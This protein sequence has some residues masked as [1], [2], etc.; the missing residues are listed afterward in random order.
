[1]QKVV[2]DTN[3]LLMPFEF[4]I[5]VDLELQGLLG[6]YEAYVPGPA[7]GE[8]KRSKNKYASVA[9]KL[10][11]KYKRYQT[12]IQGDEGII[13]AAKDLQ[14]IVVTNDALMRS[15]LRKEGIR[16]IFLRSRSHLYLEDD[17]L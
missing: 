12:E 8:L 15:K 5:N 10:A 9:L 16:C 2:L 6:T 1:M 13:A 3:A 4:K 11:G 14:A 17:Q 7:I